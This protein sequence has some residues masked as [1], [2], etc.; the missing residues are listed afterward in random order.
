MSYLNMGCRITI[1]DL[2]IDAVNSFTIT[3]SVTETSDKATITIARNLPAIRKKDMTLM[4]VL[5][6]IKAGYPVTIECGYNDNLH[7]EFTGFVRPGISAD[8]PTVIECDELFP[9]RQNKFTLSFRQVSLRNLLQ[10][11]LPRIYTIEC[12]DV[13]LGKLVID[14]STTLQIINHLKERWGLFSRVNGNT[15]SVG[16]PYDYR[17]SFTKKHDYIIGSNVRSTKG[18]KFRTDIDFNLRVNVKVYNSNGKSEV[19]SY[20]SKEPDARIRKVDY[21]TS[22]KEEAAKVAQALYKR[23]V[24]EGYQG[25]IEGFGVPRVHAG[26]TIEIVDKSQPERNGIYM[27]EGMRLDYEEAHIKR[28]SYISFKV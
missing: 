26:D 6:Y 13:N 8:F 22:S 19:V 24:Y 3:E 10:E 20:G 21:F 1:G 15:F 28:T 27:V 11:V 23:T 18:L 7:T 5:S 17:P 16:W 2:V 25:Y 12:P 14:N 4:P 9:L